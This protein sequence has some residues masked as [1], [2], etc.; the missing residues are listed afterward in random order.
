MRDSDASDGDMAKRPKSRAKSAGLL[1]SVN[2]QRAFRHLFRDSFIYLL[3]AS[4]VRKVQ[5]SELLDDE[6]LDE[7][8]DDIDIDL[9]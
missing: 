9:S 1:A 5:L 4:G 2:I 8:D 3:I 6:I 7:S